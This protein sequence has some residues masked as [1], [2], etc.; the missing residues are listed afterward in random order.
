MSVARQVGGGSSPSVSQIRLLNVSYV[1][2]NAQVNLSGVQVTYYRE[3]LCC[4]CPDLQVF[5]L[6]DSVQ[7]H[8]WHGSAIFV[9][10]CHPYGSAVHFK[11]ASLHKIGKNGGLQSEPFWQRSLPGQEVGTLQRW[12]VFLELSFCFIFLRKPVFLWNI[13]D[14]YL[15]EVLT[16]L[17][18]FSSGR[19]GILS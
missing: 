5:A 18:T 11:T 16:Y 6:F 9:A 14:G 10:Q 1:W 13:L 8:W 17:C 12:K 15:L 7:R 19:E 3:W 4:S 2:K